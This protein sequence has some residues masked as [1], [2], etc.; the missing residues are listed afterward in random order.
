LAG[1]GEAAVRPQ[2]NRR[3]RGIPHQGAGALGQVVRALRGGLADEARALKEGQL[4]C[5]AIR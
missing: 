2:P 3:Y 5:E 1:Q 4:L